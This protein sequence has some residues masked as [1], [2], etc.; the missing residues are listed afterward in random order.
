MSIIW[1]IIIGIVAGWLAG[2][3]TR[4]H[5][6]GAIADFVIGVVGAVIGGFIFDLLG[7]TAYGTMG[8][9]A[10]AVIGAIVLL[11][12]AGMLRGGRHA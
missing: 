8:S 2:L 3:I 6:F 11:A 4:G 9:L 12:V 10:M 1:F 7:I 5:G